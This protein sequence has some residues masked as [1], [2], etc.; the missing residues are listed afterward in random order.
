MKVKPVNFYVLKIEEKLKKF[1]VEI[2]KKECQLYSR[3]KMR[4]NS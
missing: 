1:C 4:K 3:L 2:P